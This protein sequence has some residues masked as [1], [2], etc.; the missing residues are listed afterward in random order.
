MQLNNLF[1]VTIVIAAL[2]L[3]LIIHMA[4]ELR[5]NLALKFYSY[6]NIGLI[7]G[8]IFLGI[9]FVTQVAYI[10]DFAIM[11]SSL[12]YYDLYTSIISFPSKFSYLAVPVIVII[13]TMIFISNLALIKHEGFRVFNLLGA[14]SGGAFAIA[15]IG[16]DF[17]A[18]LV[19]TF[20]LTYIGISKGHV[21]II[22]HSALYICALTLLCYF[23]CI[24]FSTIIMAIKAVKHRPNYDKDFMIIL[25]CSIDKRGGLLPLLK[26]R[27]N[28]AIKFAW[29]QEIETGKSM[30]YIPSGGQGPNEI[31]SEGSA[32]ELY[33]L[34]HG[35]EHDEVLPEKKSRNTYENFAFSKKIVEEQFPDGNAKVAFATTNYHILRSG[36]LAR[37]AGLDAEGIASETKWYFWPNGFVREF[38]AILALKKKV[39]IK[40]AVVIL[41]ASVLLGVAGEVILRLGI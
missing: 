1:I 34:S 35:A 28:R 37:Y 31:I 9:F 4:L 15:S 3:T 33:L 8:I 40:V 22:I 25:G 39:H 24:Y 23:E 16:L 21:L 12:S 7:S 19:E 5:K 41:A 27:T 11:G 17:A 26:S 18:R 2:M 29:E 13:S 30:R 36:I 38:V 10:V 32:M 6:T 14:I 20:L